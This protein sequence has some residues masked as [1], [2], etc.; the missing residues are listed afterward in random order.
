MNYPPTKKWKVIQRLHI[1][2]SIEVGSPE[3]NKESMEM[4][5]QLEEE[6]MEVNLPPLVQNHYH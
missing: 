2:K 1:I 6:L 3:S 4:N 5:P